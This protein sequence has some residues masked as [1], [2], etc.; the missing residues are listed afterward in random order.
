MLNHEV[1]KSDVKKHVSVF[2]P[3]ET[4]AFLSA[5]KGFSDYM[6]PFETISLERFPKHSS[7]CLF[8]P[9]TCPPETP[10]PYFLTGCAIGCDLCPPQQ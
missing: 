7:V 8:H 9:H 2:T 10:S 3:E 1:P 5:V 4:A 6:P